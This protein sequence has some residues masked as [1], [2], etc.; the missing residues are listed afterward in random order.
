M[1]SHGSGL[2]RQCDDGSSKNSDR[3]SSDF[4]AVRTAPLLHCKK[5]LQMVTFNSNTIHLENCAKE[6]ASRMQ[7]YNI[8]I[9]GIQEHK[10][11]HQNEELKFEAVERLHLV[12]SSA[13]REPTTNSS[14][15]GVDLL[16]NTKA[17]KTL[18][19]VT[20]ICNCILG[21]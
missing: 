8:D 18:W 20:S 17:R 10:R 7:K 5:M 6:L 21:S 12:I 19:N 2:T 13:W 14:Q 9:L 11:V 15:S 16:L 3:D 1:V 4:S